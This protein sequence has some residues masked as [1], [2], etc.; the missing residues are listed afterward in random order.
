MCGLVFG[1]LARDYSWH[2]LYSSICIIYSDLL[3]YMIS[4]LWR[5]TGWLAPSLRA[6]NSSNR[7]RDRDAKTISFVYVSH[8]ERY[9][10]KS[11]KSSAQSGRV[12]I[13]TKLH[14]LYCNYLGII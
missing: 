3:K 7:P 5:F 6:R 12:S 13:V 4:V 10:S 8:I 11:N 2:S 1:Y 14:K 9:K